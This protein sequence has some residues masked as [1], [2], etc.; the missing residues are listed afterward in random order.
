MAVQGMQSASDFLV[1][2]NIIWKRLWL[3]ILLFL[4]TIGVILSM[5]Y[6]AQPV[7]RATVRLQV[8]ATDRSDVSLFEQYRTGTTITD[9]QQAQNDFVR[10]LKSG[11]VAW[12]TIADLNLEI[13]AIDLLAGLSTTVEGDFIVVTVESDDPGRAEAIAM[14]EVN[15]ALEYYRDVRATPSRV[16]GEFVSEQLA[17][18][19]QKMLD[20]ETALLEFKQRHNIDSIEQETRSV[21]DLIRTLKLERDHALIERDRAEVFADVYRAEEKRASEAAAELAPEEPGEEEIAPYTRKWYIDLAR[22]HEATAIG[23]EAKRDGHARSVE[24]YD[25]MIT[26]R[27]ADLRDLLELYSEYNELG[28]ELARA[29]SNNNFL[30]DREN[31][32]RLKQ[33]Q[34]ERLG[35]IQITEPARKPDA[36]VPSRT[37][38][39]AAV[40]GVVSILVGFVLSFLLEFLSSL[41]RAARKQRVA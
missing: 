35:Y 28:R 37:L 26:E 11:F 30:W 2:V 36:P 14:T 23:Y 12:K 8:L 13:G 6:T 10:A 38:Q 24:I 41:G 15:N 21:Q 7:Y 5:S 16:L 4:V 27:T 3:T 29:T 19:T 31:E 34:A 40:G 25:S 33:V 1:Y 20:A 18:E 32:A 39:L 17:S 22:Q 9:I